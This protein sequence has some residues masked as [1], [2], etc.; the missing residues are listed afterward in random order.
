[1]SLLTDAISSALTRSRQINPFMQPGITPNASGWDLFFALPTA[2][3]P[4]AFVANTNVTAL[5]R[6]TS[7]ATGFLSQMQMTPQ[8]RLL[9]TSVESVLA[10]LCNDFGVIFAQSSDLVATNSLAADPRSLVRQWTRRIED[11]ME[12]LDWTVWMRCEDV[13]PLDHVCSVPMWPIAWA[14]RWDSN[15]VDSLKPRCMRMAV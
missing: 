4:N 11:L 7:Q 5:E 9:R 15:D 2:F 1:M 6:C 12:W 10:R 3:L 14:G 13:C 8:E